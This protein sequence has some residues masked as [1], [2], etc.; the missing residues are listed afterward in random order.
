MYVIKDLRGNYLKA[1]DET[2][3]T[4]V[5][6]I[7]KARRF[8]LSQLP[9]AIS[10]TPNSA[11]LV[12]VGRDY[13]LAELSS[14]DCQK[15][16]PCVSRR[17]FAITEPEPKKKSEPEPEPATSEESQTLREFLL[18][19]IA[20]TKKWIADPDFAKNRENAKEYTAGYGSYLFSIRRLIEEWQPPKPKSQKK[21]EQPF[22]FSSDDLR[23][24]ID[25]LVSSAFERDHKFLQILDRALGDGRPHEG[26][27]HNYYAAL[28]EV[29]A[30]VI[31]DMKTQILRGAKK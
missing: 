12:R 7:D 19:S 22:E 16:V 18:A 28:V 23:S 8:D 26:L 29:R 13:E 10:W 25:T 30:L 11:D 17:V 3:S 9:D 15:Y 6:D 21:P 31:D 5:K 27:A 1:Y 20:G 24:L 14:C 2:G 4:W